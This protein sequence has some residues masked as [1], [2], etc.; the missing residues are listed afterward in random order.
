MEDNKVLLEVENFSIVQDISE[1]QF[2]IVEVYVCHDGN[3]RHDMPIKL[4]TLKKAA[5]TLKNKYLVAGF[6]GVDFEGHEPDE[7]IVGH[8]PESGKISYKKKNGKTYLVAEAI[9]SKVYADWAYQQFVESN[10]KGVSMEISVTKTKEDNDGRTEIKEFVFNGVTIL[11]DSH[12]PACEG[13]DASIIKFSVENA[14]E[15]YSKY[16]WKSNVIVRNFVDSMGVETGKEG[17]E[18]VKEETVVTE[19]NTESLE[20][21]EN[22]AVETDETVE[23]E[24]VVEETVETTEEEVFE[25]DKE[26]VEDDDTA[27]MEDDEEKD[28]DKDSDDESKD[29][30]DKKDDKSKEKDMEA[31]EK[32]CEDES[33]DK[34]FESLTA[35]QKYQV[36]QAACK[37]KCLGY[38]ESYDDE[39][40]YVYDYCEGYIYR[41]SYTLDGTNVTIGEDKERVMRGGYV[42]FEADTE[43][44]EIV[45]TEETVTEE[46]DEAESVTNPEVETLQEEIAELKAT[47]ADY[48]AE[49][50]SLEV[51]S[52]LSGV[53]DT[54][55]PEQISNLR[56]EAKEFSL[57]RM[58][59]FSNKVKALA[60]ESVKGSES[61]YSFAR[62]AF[63]ETNAE[64]TTTGK[65]SW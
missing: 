36:F 9:M 35:E 10:H 52:I 46:T 64:P 26:K 8:F 17:T 19:I 2:A 60:F 53:I 59:E 3:N 25:G 56:E 22:V 43:T 21:T 48:E 45:T 33:E 58:G 51:E 32:D 55:S 54:L 63:G 18:V 57:D 1:E 47:I 40:L 12:T 62:V 23:K 30:S 31:E 49:K 41:H 50:K 28:D 38:L 11:G 14:S 6:D 5:S 37:D 20:N 24:T 34:K 16:S 7:M 13:A 44:K 4:S 29:K 65:Y 39:Y 61:K 15:C 27:L 42:P